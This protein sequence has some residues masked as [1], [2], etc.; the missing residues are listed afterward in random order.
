MLPRR[1]RA[2]E[3]EEHRDGSWNLFATR[4]R[5]WVLESQ[6]SLRTRIFLRVAMRFEATDV[7]YLRVSQQVLAH[8]DYH[9][10]HSLGSEVDS[11]EE[12]DHTACICS[13]G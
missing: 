7:V 4:L 12:V 6:E 1:R 9:P 8:L 10:G 3:V 11:N 5:R 2:G 13:G